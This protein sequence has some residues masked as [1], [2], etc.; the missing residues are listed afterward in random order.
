[1]VCS[2]KQR[3]CGEREL[4]RSPCIVWLFV[5]VPF[6]NNGLSFSFILLLEGNLLGILHL[7]HLF[8][9]NPE[10]FGKLC[11]GPQS[12]GGV[13]MRPDCRSTY[14]LAEMEKSTDR[15]LKH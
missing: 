9:E 13:D 10:D 2:R 5:Q 14:H 1:M 3:P 15:G 7:W 8:L 6:K 12:K 11:N 4:E